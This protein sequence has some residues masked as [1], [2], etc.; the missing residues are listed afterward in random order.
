MKTIANLRFLMNIHLN[1]MT[2][3][4]FFSIVSSFC[5]VTSCF[6]KNKNNL[7]KSLN[8]TLSI[9]RLLV[10]EIRNDLNRNSEIDSITEEWYGKLCTV[11]YRIDKVIENNQSIS[12]VF[13]DINCD[14]LNDAIA[15]IEYYT[16]GN[17]PEFTR[18][19][20]ERTDDGYKM[21]SELPLFGYRYVYVNSIENCALELKGE[22]W[23]NNDPMC[24][25]SIVKDFKVKLVGDKFEI[26]IDPVAA[27]FEKAKLV[28]DSL[29]Q[30][31]DL[32]KHKMYKLS[33]S[34][35]SEGGFSEKFYFD[36]LYRL[37]YDEERDVTGDD[38]KTYG[39]AFYGPNGTILSYSYG[40]YPRFESLWENQR[41][42]L[43]EFGLDSIIKYSIFEGAEPS[44][45]TSLENI[46]KISK[47]E[48][49]Y[50][51]DSSYYYRELGEGDKDAFDYKV[52]KISIDS[53]LFVHLF[54]DK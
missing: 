10:Q 48:F 19:Y 44:K 52:C 54:G 29:K 17:R 46:K 23:K 27:E 2:I 14:S 34:E 49:N 9:T 22:A 32:I 45:H 6:Q 39:Y 5:I 21:K 28:A 37:V 18:L 13:G 4:C 41:F 12:M 30:K 47:Q 24:C 51:S 42:Y 35:W 11:N 50:N 20:I 33:N 38:E 53:L 1:K 36:T 43:K 40:G 3:L 15:T 16:G 25:P 26:V 8:D 7:D 31:F